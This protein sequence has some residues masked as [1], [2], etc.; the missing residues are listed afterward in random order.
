MGEGIEEEAPL[1]L[2]P[3]SWL[4][5]GGEGTQIRYSTT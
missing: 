4:L 2:I 5:F 3:S 1:D